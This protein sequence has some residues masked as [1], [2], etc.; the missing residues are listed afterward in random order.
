MSIGGL[1]DIGRS[2]LITSRRAL[3][4]AAHNV[5]NAATPGYSRQSVVL[6]SISAGF[7]AMAG[8]SGRGVRVSE[9]S[10]MYDSFTS[11]QI[12]TEKANLAYWEDYETGISNVESL[13]N[14]ADDN[15]I[16][17]SI[18]DFF[19]S[20]NELYKNPVGYAG[21]ALTINR[22]EYLSS[23]IAQAGTALDDERTE[24]L[25]NSNVLVSEINKLTS[26]I[27]SLNEK[28]SIAPGLYDLQD[29][30]DSLIEKLN[31]TVK[32][33]TFEDNNH[34]YTVLVGG[35]AL[36]DGARSY[37]MSVSSD[38]VG[39]MHFKV[40]LSSTEPAREI[41][42]DITGGQ[43]KSN[44]DLRDSVIINRQNRLNAFAINVSDYINYYHR[45]GYALDGSTGNDF[46]SVN[47]ALADI[48]NPATGQITR[49][50]VTDVNAFATDKD[51]QYTIDYSNAAGAGYQQEGASGIFWRVRETTWNSTTQSWDAIADV[52]VGSVTLAY[53]NNESPN[54]RTLSFNGIKVRIDGAQ[55]GAGS[56]AAAGTGTFTLKQNR[57]AAMSMAVKLNDP[58]LV[59]AAAGDTIIIDSSND[60]IRFTEDTTAA[61]PAFKTAKI[62]AGT[63]T[64]YQLSAAVK[65]AL[66]GADTT[67]AGTYTVA[68]S[69]ATKKYTITNDAGNAKP[70]LLD[71]T[72]T[73]S[74]AAG[75]MGF[76]TTNYTPI[77]V[78]GTD[79]SDFA[80]Y[81]ILS[82]SGKAGDN[83]NA[84]L[85]AGLAED[86][87]IFSGNNTFTFY[88]TIVDDSGVEANSAK[89]N[90]GFY[91]T[92]VE[93]LEKRRQETSGVNLDEEAINLVKYQKAFQAAAKVISVADEAFT[94]LMNTVGR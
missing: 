36:V 44:L 27:S 64:R 62:A 61:S 10:R 60:T 82:S 9:I 41:T 68:Y 72:S 5:A 79:T 87:N 80:V 74:T 57:N 37:N 93:Q 4:V 86:T 77:A 11:L 12:R 19:N 92:L 71:W 30:R 75:V 65:T 21:R 29:Q 2:A 6:E 28:I 49:F 88:R 55:A 89:V 78:A 33:N 23:R 54:Y 73:I 1:F 38:N 91:K 59:A 83:M 63:Y 20:W 31:E 24:I 45:Q 56:L 52:P 67:T 22:G 69:A 90:A 81:P 34:R 76:N 50:N 25:K 18:N 17:Q 35:V 32:V 16:G 84:G 53:D 85:I 42:N 66:E 58:K 3:D 40:T 51:T 43:L 7:S 47:G 15:S 39:M 46:F 8:V 14:E 48:T 70:I 94:T 26:E 13:F